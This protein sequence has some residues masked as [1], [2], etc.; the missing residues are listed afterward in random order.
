MDRVD[1]TPG[2]P[3][4]VVDPAAP[5]GA[6]TDGAA[7]LHSGWTPGRLPRRSAPRPWK[8]LSKGPQEERFRRSVGCSGRGARCHG[9]RFLDSTGLQV[10]VTALKRAQQ[11]GGCLTLVQ[12]TPCVQRVLQI[13]QSLD[14]ILP[15]RG[16]LAKAVA[17]ATQ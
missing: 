13:T 3:P 1:N 2:R 9:N 10:L 14:R 16:D 12:P 4:P 11:G 5:E 6:G 15:V 7:A 8:R 17:E